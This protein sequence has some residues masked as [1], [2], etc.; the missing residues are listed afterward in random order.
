MAEADEVAALIAAGDDRAAFA[1]VRARLGWPHGK[2]L[3]DGELPAWLGLLGELAARRGAT[4][5]AELATGAVRD[6]DS[7]DRLYD[8][9][10]ALI[11]A[12]APAIAASVL[13][14]C[15]AL[16]GD[17]EE[18][19]CELVSALESALA[20]R[21]AFAILDEHAALRA[22]SFLCA[23]LHAFNAAMI[24][25]L[26]LTREGLAQLR[27]ET[28]ETTGMRDTLAA[29]VERAD[30]VAGAA[31]LDAA[32]LR[33]WHYV[34][35]GGILIHQ[36]PYGFDEPMRGRY[37]WLQDSHAHV[38]SGLAR[39]HPLVTGMAIEC[40]YAPP[41]RG[42]EIVAEAASGKLGLPVAPWP[43]VGN[44]AP[45]L[46]VIYDLADLPAAEV[47]RLVQRRADQIL[48]AHASPWTQDSPIAPDVT[49]LL[50]QTLVPPW[51]DDGP[52]AAHVA[53]IVASAGLSADDLAADEP[54]RWQAL[55]ARAWPPS[56]GQRARLW[57]GGPVDSNRFD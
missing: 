3:P 21:D 14:R 30:R 17:S 6:P 42:N 53:S 26:D 49:T 24:G 9:G 18:V 36:S 1:R 52:A 47:Q 43:A 55:V 13:W 22:R 54:A 39:L 50:Y 11:D 48:F 5:L 31:P 33:G 23:Y 51:R 25:R 41:G 8:L 2:A 32:D 57:A 27:P 28:P 7:P 56:P 46:V 35:T 12:G 16:V 34:L 44:P 37:A 15:L 20:Y 19:V 40:I 10:Y 29:I 4:Q 45:G 38:A